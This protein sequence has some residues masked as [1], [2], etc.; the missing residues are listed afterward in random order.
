MSERSFRLNKMRPASEEEKKLISVFASQMSGAERDQ[1][2][3]DIKELAAKEATLDGSRVIFEIAGY[4]RPPYEGQ[5]SFGVEGRMRDRDG[6]EITIVL[7]ADQNNRLLELE[8]I[9]WDLHDLIDPIW[10]SLKIY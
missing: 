2:K 3:E 8:F 10:E 6:I 5:H 9:R 1:L 7:Y 4:H